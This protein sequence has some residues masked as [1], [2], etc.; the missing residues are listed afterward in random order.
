MENL[1]NVQ[2]IEEKRPASLLNGKIIFGILAIVI[3]IE[4]IFLVQ[5]LLS[6]PQVRVAALQPLGE[7]QIVLTSDKT[8]VP[9]GDEFKVNIKISTG[10]HSSLG[11]DLIL[12]YDPKRVEAIKINKGQI[13][14]EYPTEEIVAKDGIIRISGI[15]TGDFSGMGN[16]AQVEF[17]GKLKGQTSITAEFKPGLTTDS[18]IID[19]Q[20]K[21]ILGAVYN[22][23]LTVG[24]AKLAEAL[25]PSCEGFSQ[26]CVDKNG[27]QG[28][29]K[30]QGGKILENQCT[31]D[32]YL[33]LSCETCQT[34]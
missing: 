21:D 8:G 25:T 22:L 27:K 17:K 34:K 16:F 26:V 11:A 13:Y 12:N 9:V 2:I 5:T 19:T 15:T 31:F 10:G 14:Q 23:D 18:N 3:I 32:P 24:E 20:T 29:Q 6:P 4:L 30:C 28:I 1:P 33:T 7:G